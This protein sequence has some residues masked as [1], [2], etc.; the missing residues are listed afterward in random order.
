M[1]V[2]RIG[3]KQIGLSLT[4]ITV[5]PMVEDDMLSFTVPY[6]MFMEENFKGSFLEKHLWH[7]IVEKM[8]SI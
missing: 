6:K 8:N 3:V 5:R 4:D 7:K 1:F 2:K